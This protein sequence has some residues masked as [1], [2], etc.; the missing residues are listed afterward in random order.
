MPADDRLGSNEDQGFPPPPPE[1]MQPYPEE[2]VGESDSWALYLLAQRGQLL[3]QREV[4]Q[5]EVGARSERGP[6][7]GEGDPSKRTMARESP[8]VLG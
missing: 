3:P 8:P 1:A 7:G 5:R 2:P 6:E 4:L